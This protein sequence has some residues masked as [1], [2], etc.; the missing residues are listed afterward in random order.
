MP[1]STIFIVRR[2]AMRFKK[3]QASFEVAEPNRRRKKSFSAV[4]FAALDQAADLF[5]NELNHGVLLVADDCPFNQNSHAPV[6]IRHQMRF[7]PSVFR[8]WSCDLRE[9]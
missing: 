9:E 2:I 6:F 4:L 8:F 5:E 1:L 7:S 3:A